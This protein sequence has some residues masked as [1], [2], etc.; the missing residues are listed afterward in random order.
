MARFTITVGEPICFSCKHLNLLNIDKFACKA[1]E[2]G[3]PKEI[4]RSENNHSKPF[5]GDNGIRFE[6]IN[7]EA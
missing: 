5:K 6:S 3:I 7:E 2:E 1:F 4:I